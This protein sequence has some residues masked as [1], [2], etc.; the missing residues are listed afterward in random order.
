[1]GFG[2]SRG[3]RLVGYDAGVAK[4]ATQFLTGFCLVLIAALLAGP[5]RA[6]PADEVRQVSLSVKIDEQ[7]V[8]EDIRLPLAYALGN[9]LDGVSLSEYRRLDPAAV[10]NTLAAMMVELNP[11][12]IDGIVVRPVVRDVRLESFAAIQP[13]SAFAEAELLASGALAFTAEYA[14]LGKPRTVSL[15]WRQIVPERKAPVVGLI[16]DT[17]GGG[18]ENNP[19]LVVAS[20][21]ADGKATLAVFSAKE[22][23]HV[24]HSGAAIEPPNLTA[25]PMPEPARVWIAVLPL[26]I[27]L[28][29]TVVAYRIK[30]LG[31]SLVA[32]SVAFGLAGLS[33]VFRIGYVPVGMTAA[34]LQPPAE[35]EAIEVFT[36]LHRNIYRAFDYTDESAIYDALA[37]SVDGPELEEI[38]NDVYQSLI[39]RDAGGVVCKV[40]AVRIDEAELLPK[41][42]NDTTRSFRIRCV[43]EVDGLVQ[44]HGHTHARTN[45]FEAIYTLAPRYGQWRIVETDV[46]EQQRA[47]D[48]KQTLEGLF[49]LDE[50][51]LDSDAAAWKGGELED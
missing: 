9:V 40:Q 47:D 24:W 45:Q 39:L 3:H 11:V 43:W 4:H 44:H 46:V 13:I 49:D 17:A 28:V 23:E 12:A 42:E 41:D 7:S 21:E 37:Q 33:V 8:T 20:I 15:I 14:T 32:L 30:K 5:C 2:R 1:M 36:A 19:G 48:G 51:T 50:P 18:G 26:V 35:D 22:P 27:A 29:G 38:Y 10:E 25:A 16:G 34:G 6:H 31:L